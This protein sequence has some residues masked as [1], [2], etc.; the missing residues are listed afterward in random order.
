MKRLPD[1]ETYQESYDVLVLS[2]GSSPVRPPIPGIESER[3]QTLWTVP[4]TDRIRSLIKEQNVR[5]AAVIGGGFIGLEMAENLRHQGLNVSLIE[6][7]DQ[8]M[9][10]WITNIAAA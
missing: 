8:V 5:S 6:M 2:T 10:P 3:I 9:T 1:G 7:L 4:D